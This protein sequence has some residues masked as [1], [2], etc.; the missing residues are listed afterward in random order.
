MKLIRTVVLAILLI[1]GASAASA[2]VVVHHINVGQADATLLEFKSAAVLV[3]AG[4]EE[5]SDGKHLLE[6]LRSFFQRRSDLKKIFHTI[7]ITHPHIDHTRFIVDV[8]REFRPINFVDNG[9]LKGSGIKPLNEARSLVK[10]NNATSANKIYYSSINGSMIGPHGYSPPG[11]Q[12]LRDSPSEVDM[13]F[14]NGFRGCED[15][16][17]DSVVVLITYKLGKFLIT[18][19]AEWEDKNCKPAI[20]RMQALFKHSGLLDV[21][22][23]KVGH[24]GSRNG[25]S[26]SFL[27]A[28][29]PQISIISA[30]HHSYRDPSGHGYDAWTYGHPREVTVAWLESV[31]SGTRPLKT[32]YTMDDQRQIH[33]NRKVNKAVY[34]TCWDGDIVVRTDK[35][36]K[37]LKV[38]TEK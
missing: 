36:G 23:Y 37:N 17:N 11:I 10:K 12:S 27:A 3:D 2:Q 1:L 4:G 15:E 29:T 38:K 34:C 8:M 35:N 19:D 32:A 16:N 13:R 24:H 25:T 30:G 5:D 14:L 6:Y 7:V 31:T 20:D 22:V 9:G 26:L 33:A 21:D 28:L 18:G